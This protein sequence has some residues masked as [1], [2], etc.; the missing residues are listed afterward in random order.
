MQKSGQ[1]GKISVSIG[2]E[3]ELNELKNL[4]VIT[5][6]YKAGDRTVGILGIVGPKHMEYTRMMSLVNF[7]GEMLGTAIQNWQASLE[8]KEDK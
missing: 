5:S 3:N 8:K 1:G 6:A 4:S 7:I 2:A